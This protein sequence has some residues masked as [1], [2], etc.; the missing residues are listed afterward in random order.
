MF[1]K[2]LN[3]GRLGVK[4]VKGVF[5]LEAILKLY[6]RRE[7]ISTQHKT[8]WNSPNL[9]TGSA[10]IFFFQAEPGFRHFLSTA[11]FVHSGLNSTQLKIK[12]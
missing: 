10:F 11:N 9:P 1:L 12:M 8:E 2:I 7:G 5:F 4:E 6:A 3:V